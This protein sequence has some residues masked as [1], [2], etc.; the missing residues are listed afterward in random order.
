VDISGRVA[1]LGR[2][3]YTARRFFLK[4]ADRILFGTDRYPG[5]TAQPRHRL[6]YRFLETD[7]EYFKYYDHPF[8][9]AGDWRIYGLFLPDDVLRKVYHENADRI[10]GPMPS[11]PSSRMRNQ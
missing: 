2:Q 3:P 8:P 7:D 5:R 4:Y 6:Y 9:P 10:F 1:E 11:S